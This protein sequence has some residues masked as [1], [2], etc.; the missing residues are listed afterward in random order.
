MCTALN[1]KTARALCGEAHMSPDQT[2]EDNTEGLAEERSQQLKITPLPTGIR[3]L[4]STFRRSYSGFREFDNDWKT[5][6]DM[7]IKTFAFTYRFSFTGSGVA[8][9]RACEEIDS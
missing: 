9:A 8:N 4:D 1:E 2:A 7:R 3:N 6:R 5:M